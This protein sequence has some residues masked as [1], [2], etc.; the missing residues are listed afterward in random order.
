MMEEERGKVH[1]LQ[2]VE[3]PFEIIVVSAPLLFPCPSS[4][5]LLCMLPAALFR[6][7]PF[8][9]RQLKLGKPIQ[10][11]ILLQWR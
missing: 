1:Q 10:L 9:V 11:A 7:P 8:E 2:S 5:L 4:C 3:V 6:F